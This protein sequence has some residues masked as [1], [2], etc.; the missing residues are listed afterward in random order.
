MITHPMFAAV[1]ALLPPCPIHRLFG[2]QCPGCGLTRSFLYCFA[3]AWPSAIRLHPLGP[4]LFAQVVVAAV[5]LPPSR[6]LNSKHRS[7]LASICNIVIRIDVVALLA[8]W[9][10]RG[11]S[12]YVF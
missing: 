9:L 8:I 12:G 2:V 7:L 5:I 4:A 1:V 3:G 6:F 11:V 10:Y